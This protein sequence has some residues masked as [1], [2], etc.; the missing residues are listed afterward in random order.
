MLAWITTDQRRHRRAATL[1]G[2]AE[3]LWTDIGTSI[4]AFGHYLDHHNACER[5]IRAALGDTAFTGAFREGQV[6][7]YQEA[8]AYA[9]D[10]R[11]RPA[12]RPRHEPHAPLTRR[13]R[14]VAGLLAD[15]LSNREIAAALVISPRT[16]ESHVENIL[17]KLGL[18]NRTQVAAWTAR[19]RA[20]A[21]GPAGRRSG[22]GASRP[23]AGNA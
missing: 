3:V 11:P 12:G 5:R 7:T 6:M 14:E 15:G 23:T 18:T 4:T 22:P 19:H 21:D 17:T 16:A 2:A 8:I 1:L 10:E 20:A 9:L 13:E